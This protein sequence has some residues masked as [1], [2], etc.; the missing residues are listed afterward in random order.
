VSVPARPTKRSTR[1]STRGRLAFFLLG[2]ALL[3]GIQLA[4]E[5]DDLGAAVFVA[6]ALLFQPLSRRFGEHDPDLHL[7]DGREPPFRVSALSFGFAVA[8]GTLLSVVLP[9]QLGVWLFFW[10]VLWPWLEL[11]TALARRDIARRGVASWRPMR[12]FRDPALV[13]VAVTVFMT[14]ALVIDGYDVVEAAAWG[15]V[16]GGV[17]F[18]VTVVIATAARREFH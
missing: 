15:L 1:L 16:C 4:T 5:S 3:V 17:C 9:E 11:F 8:W 10:V 12:P 7:T 13:S 2:G 18:A 14:G 6:L